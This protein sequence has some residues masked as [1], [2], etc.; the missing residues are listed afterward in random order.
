MSPRN[1][2][3]E[4]SAEQQRA[5]QKRSPEPSRLRSIPVGQGKLPP[6]RQSYQSR[7]LSP[8][9][10]PRSTSLESPRATV[11]VL[12]RNSSRSAMTPDIRFSTPTSKVTV[13]TTPTNK[14]SAVNAE[15]KKS[16]GGDSSRGNSPLLSSKKSNYLSGLN[17]SNRFA[18]L[19]VESP[20]K[21][22]PLE[23]DA[24]DI[25]MQSDEK[26]V[27]KPRP[28]DISYSAENH[29]HFLLNVRL[30]SLAQ[31]LLF[32]IL[33][34]RTV[35]VVGD[36]QSKV[37]LSLPLFTPLFRKRADLRAQEL[38]KVTVEALSMFVPGH[39]ES[40]I[41]EWRDEPLNIVHLCQLKLVGLSSSFDLTRLR[42]LVSVLDVDRNTFDGPI[43]NPT[44]LSDSFLSKML[45]TPD[46]HQV[47]RP[48]LSSFK[49]AL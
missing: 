31:H 5:S 30:A 28:G 49:V 34:G 40:K 21:Q 9:H 17:I 46:P 35:V 29:L 11:P 6:L 44:K 20:S 32:S 43:Y 19:N 39:A 10:T 22:A 24:P 45:G 12:L 16:N 8:S 7:S 15:E 1:V 48:S 4:F 37:A 38:V 33:S 13:W 2:P 42:R 25:W 47:S 3:S 41:V 14:K 26:Y 27:R 18:G 23:S 36:P